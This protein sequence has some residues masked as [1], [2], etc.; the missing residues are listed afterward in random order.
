MRCTLDS[1][2]EAG[3]D[4]YLYQ[5]FPNLRMPQPS[6]TSENNW[7]PTQT[8]NHSSDQHMRLKVAVIRNKVCSGVSA[9]DYKTRCNTC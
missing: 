7:R 9:L 5:P 6:L 3:G 4:L 2:K 8:F 1:L